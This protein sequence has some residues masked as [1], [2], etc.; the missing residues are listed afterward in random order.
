MTGWEQLDDELERWHAAGSRATFWWRDDDAVDATPQ[1]DR[2][3]R[4]AESIPIALAVIPAKARAT[5]AE[6]IAGCAMIAVLQHGWSHTSH[7]GDHDEFPANRPFDDVSRE[8]AQGRSTLAQ[9][10]GRQSL[11]IFV[12]PWHAFDPLFLP[13]LGAN[14][15]VGLSRKGPRPARSTGEGVVLANAHV[16]PIVWSTPAGFANDDTYLAQIVDHLE[17]RRTG[18]YDRSEPTGL[19]THHLDQTAESFH[20]IDRFAGVVCHHPGAMWCSAEQIFGATS[21]VSS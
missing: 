13:L 15:L 21:E 1:L 9:L 20:F 14:E 12:P 2:L 18:R 7:H 19:L 10:F 8:L 17:G 5:L 16:S 4:S 3:L 6:R 11:P